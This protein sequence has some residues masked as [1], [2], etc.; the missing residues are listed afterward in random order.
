MKKINAIFNIKLVLVFIVLSSVSCSKDS[1]DPS[2]S[3]GTVTVSNFTK[4]LN[5][6]PENGLL[7]GNIVAS[8][9][10]GT[11]AFSL[12]EQ[13][14]EGALYLDAA[15]GALKVANETLFDFE[16]NQ[17]ITGTVKVI[18]GDVS[19][20]A[21]ITITL[22][23]LEEDNI[24]EGSI[25]LKTQQEV[26]D[27]GVNNYTR[28]IGSVTIGSVEEFVYS[29]II[30]LSPLQSI[31]KVDYSLS[32]VRNSKLTSTV[33][34]N[35][36]EVGYQL[37]IVENATLKTLEG[38][39]NI[40]SLSF[41]LFLFGNNELSNVSQLGS[42]MEIGSLVLINCPLIP[43]IDFLSNITSLKNLNIDSCD[44]LKNLDGLS[45]LTNMTGD[46]PYVEIRN[47]TL[48]E[49]L[50][51]LQNLNASVLNLKVD[52]NP[53]LITLRGLENIIPFQDLYIARNNSLQNLNG[54][55]NIEVLSFTASILH[56]PSLTNLDGLNNL[57]TTNNGIIIEN[58]ST[59]LS[60]E[61]FENLINC[62]TLLAKN[63]ENLSNFC[64]IQNLV[65][66]NNNLWLQIAN[67]AY[68]PT[69]QDIIDGN[70]SL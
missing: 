40:T 59:L 31:R 61:G 14:P 30:D 25:E 20:T 15:T 60:L 10:N 46:Y 32:V 64:A 23:D 17:I 16:T 69:K 34:L 29:D 45:N 33:G 38:L 5:E 53:N 48:L 7:I 8:T 12:V 65:L 13:S 67:N 70:C 4:T 43:N 63:N 35:I 3:G 44:T 54:L 39:E 68:N 26:N 27:F 21:Q 57:H 66:E 52:G 9:N 19:K 55:E 42:L 24:Y 2:Q 62:S 28:I 6:N 18:N 49:N 51:G 36:D 1:D 58:N 47:N 56:N 41:G 50:N 11:L 22:I 37:S